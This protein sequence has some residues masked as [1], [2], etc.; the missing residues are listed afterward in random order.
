MPKKAYQAPVIRRVGS[1]H[2]LTQVINKNDNNTPD[3]YA[4]HHITLTS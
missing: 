3:G 1:L 2:E 4:Y